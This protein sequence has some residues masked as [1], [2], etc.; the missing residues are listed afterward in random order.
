MGIPAYT[1]ERFAMRHKGVNKLHLDFTE[2]VN[3]GSRH[4]IG[5]ISGLSYSFEV[6]NKSVLIRPTIG[7]FAKV[8]GRINE[9]EEIVF[10]LY[11]RIGKEVPLHDLHAGIF[12][13]AFLA[14]L[15]ANGHIYNTI[16]DQWGAGTT[17]FRQ[18]T[19]LANE[20]LSVEQKVLKTWSGKKALQHGFRH[21]EAVSETRL[22]VG[23]YEFLFYR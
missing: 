20:R 12:Y 6:D 11:T 5:G 14:F 23:Q 8:W 13:D 7:N 10:H 19:E 16:R 9:K 18:Y 22:G 4:T 3:V 15:I 1:L 21:V 17:N 2:E